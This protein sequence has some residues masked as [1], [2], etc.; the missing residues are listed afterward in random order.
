MPCGGC[1]MEIMR[2]FA[3]RLLICIPLA[4]AYLLLNF[5]MAQRRF[6]WSFGLVPCG[7][8][9]VG[10]VALFHAHPAQVALVLGTL[11][12]IAVALLVAGIVAQ[13]RRA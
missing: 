13:R 10:G 7:A 4:L 12:G 5:E 8:A 1:E 9:Y 3:G 11:N 2:T 6:F